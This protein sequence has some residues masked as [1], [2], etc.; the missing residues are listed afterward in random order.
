M[1]K[2]PTALVVTA[3]LLSQLHKFFCAALGEIVSGTWESIPVYP[4]CKM[5]DM[6]EA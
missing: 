1:K 6:E 2:S 3:L 4:L 5:G